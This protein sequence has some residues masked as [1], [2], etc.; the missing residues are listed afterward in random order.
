MDPLE[1]EE[2]HP[3][4]SA[5]AVR[6]HAH[7]YS[8]NQ[9]RTACML[10]KLYMEAYP[11]ISTII[12]FA[13]L[14]LVVILFV[15]TT[16][17]TDRR[18]QLTHDY[19]RIDAHY[20]FRAARIDHWCLFGGDDSCQCDDFTEPTSREEM[21]GWL[22]AHRENVK[23]AQ[24]SVKKDLDV[25]FVGDEVTELWNGRLMNLPISLNPN[26][27]AIKEYF[28]RTFTKKGGGQFEGLALGIAGDSVR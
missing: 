9:C 3:R 22:E 18:H 21:K 14:L 6:S 20:N 8:S 2:L 15:E 26:G 1:M 5:R 25:V 17:H 24:A 23:R 7:H 19:S 10:L 13:L 28:D 16:T 27:Q 12:F 4:P 11:L